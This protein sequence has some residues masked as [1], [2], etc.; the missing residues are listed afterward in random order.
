MRA[1]SF[2]RMGVEDYVKLVTCSLHR[3]HYYG[4]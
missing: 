1:I 4:Q 2:R 3:G